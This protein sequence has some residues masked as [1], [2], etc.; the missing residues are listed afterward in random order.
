LNIEAIIQ[1]LKERRHQIDLAIVSL[2]ALL[3]GEKRRGRP[4][5]WIAEIA[6]DLRESAPEEPV[7]SSADEN[8]R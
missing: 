3:D 6:R 2:T 7:P 5:K 8:R 4:P 1:Q